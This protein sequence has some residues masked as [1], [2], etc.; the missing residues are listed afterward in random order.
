MQQPQQAY[1]QPAA[2]QQ[3]QAVMAP[4]QPAYNYQ[5]PQALAQPQAPFSVQCPVFSPTHNIQAEGSGFR[6][7]FQ[8]PAGSPQPVW[9][10]VHY[11]LNGQERNIRMINNNNG[12]WSHQERELT[13]RAGD[14]L[15]YYFTYCVLVNGIQVD[16]DTPRFSFLVAQ[17]PAPL[18]QPQQAPYSAPQAQQAPYSAPQAQQA[19]YQA[20]QAQQAPYQAPQ[21]QQ[22]PYQAPQAVMQPAPQCPTCPVLQF[23]QLV[24]LMSNGQ[25]KISFT[26][27]GPTPAWVDVHFQVNGGDLFNVRMANNGAGAFEHLET[28]INTLMREDST[29]KFFFTYCVMINGCQVDCDTD[30]FQFSKPRPAP[31]VQPQQAPY[32]APQAQQAPYQ[33]PQAQQAP[34]QAPQA[35]QAPYSAPQAQ[36]A[37]YQ[38]PQAQMQA[39]YSAP[40]PLSA[41]APYS[42]PAPLSVPTPYASPAAPAFA[43]PAMQAFLPQAYGFGG[44]FPLIPGINSP[45]ILGHQWFH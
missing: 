27:Q 42:A 26:P 17:Q 30:L 38:A 1:S 33:A 19:P 14:T 13:I 36:Q 37:P 12:A 11:T 7:S 35:Q 40:A 18:V 4:Q 5:Q 39:P 10:D 31:L 2:F 21:A 8:T 23:S 3:P 28:G 15:S 24:S 32:Q 29:L 16:C 41:P 9:V 20:P 34:Y 6:I 44:G 43:A 45:G 25:F 22:A